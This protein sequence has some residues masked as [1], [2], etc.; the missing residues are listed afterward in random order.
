MKITRRNFL[1]YSGIAGT[2]GLITVSGLVN[3]PL[4]FVSLA[5]GEE[6]G[7]TFAYISDS[8]L[9][10][11]PGYAREHRFTRALKKAVAD[12]N[13]I[14]PAPDFVLYGG[15]LAQLGLKEELDLGRGILADLKPKLHMMVGEHDWYYDLGDKW[16]ELFGKPWYSFDHKG[17]HFV[18]LNSVVVEDYWSAGN[19]SQMER[20]LFM[21]QLDNPKGKPFTVGKGY[22]GNTQVEW[23]KKDL[24]KVAKNTPVLV[25]SHSPLYKYYKSWN[26]WTDDAGDIQKILAPFKNV[27]VLHGHTHQVLLNRIKNI[28]FYGML[29]TAWPWPYAPQGL[30]ELT[31]QMDRSDPFNQFDACG[32][33]KIMFGSKGGADK[34]YDLW[35]REPM[36]VAFKDVVAGK[37][38]SQPEAQHSGPSY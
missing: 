10:V 29:S 3:S 36:M 8:H 9:I 16:Q 30:P 1:T 35:D 21:A 32:T 14:S 2:T 7:F 22:L 17:V 37:V 18:V 23:L 31:R 20:M 13:T 4:N 34:I 6:H 25:F 26:F 27:T 15:D 19:M 5:Y 24:A 38:P 12:V 28:T 33:G 11:K